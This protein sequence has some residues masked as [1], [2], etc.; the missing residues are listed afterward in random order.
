MVS[1]LEVVCVCNEVNPET[2]NF[3]KSKSEY[4]LIN[5]IDIPRNE[6]SF[7]SW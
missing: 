7:S 2:H 5:F 4:E 6:G 3:E 1:Q